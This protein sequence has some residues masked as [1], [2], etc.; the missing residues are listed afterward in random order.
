[1]NT[2]IEE[3]ATAFGWPTNDLLYDLVNYHKAY[4]TSNVAFRPIT[5]CLST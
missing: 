1:M 5:T 3:I 4:E 2:F